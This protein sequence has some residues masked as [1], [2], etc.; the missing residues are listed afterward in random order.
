VHAHC[1]A[2]RTIADHGPAFSGRGA[3]LTFGNRFGVLAVVGLLSLAGVV[4]AAAQE[5]VSSEEACRLVHDFG[6]LRFKDARGL[7]DACARA[8]AEA[9]KSRG[10]GFGSSTDS[11]PAPVSTPS[12]PASER[13]RA[14]YVRDD[15]IDAEFVGGVLIHPKMKAIHKAIRAT[16]AIVPRTRLIPTATGYRLQLC[17]YRPMSGLP[18]CKGEAFAKQRVGA[19]CSGFLIA[20]DKIATA[21]HCITW[22]DVHE[23]DPNP[24]SNKYAVVFNFETKDGVEREDFREDE[25]YEI[26]RLIER[27]KEGSGDGL[28]DFAVIE[29]RQGVPTSIAVPLRLAGPVGLPVHKD[30]QLGVIGHPDGLPKKVSFCDNTNRAME[31]GRGT[32][33]RGQLNTFHGNSGS[34][35]LFYDEPDVVAGIL[36]EGEKD[37]AVDSASACVRTVVYASDQMCKDER[38]SEKVTK[39]AV[40]EPFVGA[41]ADSAM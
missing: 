21:G 35:V 6:L 9:S 23:F 13:P 10:T 3:F 18:L 31:E 7:V 34:P 4:P 33:F 5:D 20:P 2:S 32:I 8:G 12:D 41:K 25:V 28:R 36:V 11:L 29:L 17:A 1:R 30:T 26:R 38:C 19:H 22:Q 16:V 14:I 37:F 15:R 39:S 27:Y 40:L 24:D